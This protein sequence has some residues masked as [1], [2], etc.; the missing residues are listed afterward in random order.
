MGIIITF[1]PALRIIVTMISSPNTMSE[2]SIFTGSMLALSRPKISRTV[3]SS[4]VS[5]PLPPEPVFFDS[6]TFFKCRAANIG[7]QNVSEGFGAVYVRLN[8]VYLSA[9]RFP[10]LMF[11]LLRHFRRKW[12]QNYHFVVP[13]KLG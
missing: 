11:C 10:R 1:P 2:S 12:R 6:V 9:N 7:P 5:S 3:S 4:S 13:Y 8:A